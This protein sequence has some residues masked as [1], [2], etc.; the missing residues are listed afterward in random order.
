MAEDNAPAAQG[1]PAKDAGATKPAEQAPHLS[2]DGTILFGMTGVN[3]ALGQGL[4]EL[5][6]LG[7]PE[8]AQAIQAIRAAQAIRTA[9]AAA[10][11]MSELNV[12]RAIDAT[13]AWKAANALKEANALETATLR[14]ATLDAEALG[15]AAVPLAGAFGVAGVALAFGMA[16]AIP[17]AEGTRQLIE[18]QAKKVQHAVAVDYASRHEAPPEEPTACVDLLSGLDLCA[19]ARIP[20][21]WADRDRVQADYLDA[22]GQARVDAVQEQELHD[23]IARRRNAALTQLLNPPDPE[24]APA[25]TDQE[26]LLKAYPR[27]GVPWAAQPTDQEALLKAYPRPGVPWAAQPDEPNMSPVP[28]DEPN[29]CFEP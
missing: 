12:A 24:N 7:A 21:S 17:V 15:E 8:V 27:P 13:E 29:A 10:A 16:A 23:D 22:R 11:D 19:E 4:A 25:P 2:E 6:M 9:E 20:P 5:P 28:P 18:P 26:A 1:D 3:F 14:A